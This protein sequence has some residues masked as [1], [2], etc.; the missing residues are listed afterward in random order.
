MHEGRGLQCVA[1][2]LV[3]HVPMGEPAQFLIDE[4]RQL[5][6]SCLVSVAPRQKELR[7]FKW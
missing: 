5:L 3:T 6:Q 7:D 4:R 1:R 2:T